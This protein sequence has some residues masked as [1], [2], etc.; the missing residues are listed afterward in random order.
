MSNVIQY[1]LPFLPEL[2][3]AF[4]A[5]QLLA[6]GV[7]GKTDRTNIVRYVAIGLLIAFAFIGLIAGVPGVD[8][9]KGA[10]VNDKLSYISKTILGMSAAAALLLSA[11]YLKSEKFDKYEFS[12]LVLYAVLG[13]SI[14]VSS[15]SLLSLYIGIEMQSLALYVLAAFN[16]DSLRASEA[17]LKYFVLGAISSGLLLYGISLVYGFTG[18]ISYNGI[19][20]AVASGNSCLLYTSPSPRDA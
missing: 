9:F 7:G 1:I 19:A 8:A 10:L 6:F 16:R 12:I 14:M 11:D 15:N 17:G 3:L 4:G 2:F 5:S 18:T 20:Q 13:M